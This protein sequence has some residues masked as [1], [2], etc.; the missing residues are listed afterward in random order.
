MY[1]P[2]LNK[3]EQ[4]GVKITRAR[5]AGTA[6]R[7]GFCNFRSQATIDEIGKAARNS[8]SIEASKIKAAFKG[9]AF[10]DHGEDSRI[11]VWFFFNP[12]RQDHEFRVRWF[13]GAYVEPAVAL[14]FGR[15]LGKALEFLGLLQNR[16]S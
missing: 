7:R 1:Q 2:A 3:N 12:Q 8:Q 10:R 14:R 16:W 11:E 4:S 9:F 5:L 13:E 15:V 6:V